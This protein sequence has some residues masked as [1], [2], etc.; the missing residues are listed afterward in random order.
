MNTQQQ[1]S[2]EIA[3]VKDHLTGL[4]GQL[5]RNTELNCL[6]TDCQTLHVE[7]R[8]NGKIIANQN[9]DFQN[10]NAHDNTMM[11]AAK[12]IYPRALLNTNIAA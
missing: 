1:R 3:S 12:E 10:P 6:V 11:F 2:H 7:L 4:A 5:P 9:F 8:Q